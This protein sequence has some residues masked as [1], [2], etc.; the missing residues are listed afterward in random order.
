MLIC[1][2]VT[3]RLPIFLAPR[4]DTCQLNDLWAYPVDNHWQ[5]QL[6]IFESQNR[7]AQFQMCH[8]QP[9]KPCSHLYFC[10]KTAMTKMCDASS[11]VPTANQMLQFIERVNY[12]DTINVI[13]QS[14]QGDTTNPTSCNLRCGSRWSVSSPF[15]RAQLS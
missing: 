9:L 10:N 13:A 3:W 7:C 1:T 8:H 15:I 2:Y 5:E 4:V 12:S 11:V 14:Y 6:V